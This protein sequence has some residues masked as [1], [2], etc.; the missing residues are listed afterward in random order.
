MAVTTHAGATC[1]ASRKPVARTCSLARA[2]RCPRPRLRDKAR[3]LAGRLAGA[4]MVPPLVDVTVTAFS[5]TCSWETSSYMCRIS[6]SHKKPRLRQSNGCRHRV[7]ALCRRSPRSLPAEFA[8]RTAIRMVRRPPEIGPPLSGLLVHVHVLV[9]GCSS[10]AGDA[11]SEFPMHSCDLW[12]PPP[13]GVW[14]TPSRTPTRPPR[15]VS[16]SGGA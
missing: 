12:G 10:T 7:C 6:G 14:P 2:R 8:A 13:P 15:G 3:R 1:T 5:P 16:V 11:P 9:R 4:P